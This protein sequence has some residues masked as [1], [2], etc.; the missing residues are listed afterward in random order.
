MS[1]LV[2]YKQSFLELVCIIDAV[3]F[4]QYFERDGEYVKARARND[5]VIKNSYSLEDILFK[6]AVN[7]AKGYFAGTYNNPKTLLGVYRFRVTSDDKSEESDIES[8]N[9]E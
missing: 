8:T 4:D 9:S 6:T 5:P 1:F 3:T 2:L 7:H